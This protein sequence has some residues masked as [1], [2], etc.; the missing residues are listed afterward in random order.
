MPEESQRV[1]IKSAT[2]VFG[3]PVGGQEILQRPKPL[4][5]RMGQRLIDAETEHA[6]TATDLPAQLIGHRGAHFQG[7]E[8]VG[9]GHLYYVD[10]DLIVSRGFSCAQNR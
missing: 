8:E 6:G 9:C 2:G 7:A 5:Q 3:S 4:L 10:F 1:Y